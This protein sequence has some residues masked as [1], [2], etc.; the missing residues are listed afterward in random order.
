MNAKN[1]VEKIL[2]LF[3]AAFGYCPA[4]DQFI[5]D[6]LGPLVEEF[7]RLKEGVA[8]RDAKIFVLRRRPVCR[9]IC[10]T[11]APPNVPEGT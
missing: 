9:C 1:E 11:A 7:E 2:R 10:P 6:H 4:E 5:R 8:E 3:G